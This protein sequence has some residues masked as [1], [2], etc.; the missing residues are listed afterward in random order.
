MSHAVGPQK[1]VTTSITV[2]PQFSSTYQI[3]RCL[4]VRVSDML[5]PVLP[6]RTDNPAQAL[7]LSYAGYFAGHEFAV[8]VFNPSS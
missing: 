6:A 8:F 3:Q 7:S 2:F 4:S 5:A 1:G